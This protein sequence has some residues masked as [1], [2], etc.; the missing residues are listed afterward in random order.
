MQENSQNK[1]TRLIN[2][3]GVLIQ[4]HR[5][6]QGKT[7]YAISA[8]VSM[9]KSTWREAEIGACKDI[10]FTTLWKIAEGLDIPLAKLIEELNQKLG[11]NFSLS[12]IK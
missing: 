10:K 11:E 4:Q 2:T 12:D 1:T 9:S 6:E 7:I 3:L 8:E 5:K